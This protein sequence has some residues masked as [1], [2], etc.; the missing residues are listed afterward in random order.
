VLRNRPDLV[1]QWSDEQVA[2]RWWDLFPARKDRNGKPAEPEAHEL[3]MLLP[4]MATIRGRL[5]SMS[6]FMRCLAEP[7]AR[8]SNREDGCSGR[9]WEGRYRCQRLLDEAAVLACSV[10]VDLNPIRA[11]IAQTPETSEYTSAYERIHA[12][13]PES[14][15]NAAAPGYNRAL[16]RPKSPSQRNGPGARRLPRDGWLSPIDLDSQN[17]AGGRDEPLACHRRSSD[18]GFLSMSREQ[19]L[20]ILDW[21]GRQVRT[22]KRGSIPGH[23]VPIFE[24]LGL[25][26]EEWVETV[27]QF[28]RRFHRAAGRPA[29]LAREA[30]RHGR[31]WFHGLRTARTAFS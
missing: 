29:G 28:G 14:A 5:S 12:H 31:R 30:A 26:T 8:R 23:L 3:R 2:R 6:W 16:P 10:Y 15:G 24:R 4:A 20:E 22:D 1:A 19:Y 18:K 21:T 9:F 11:G 25:A 7:I 17:A 27:R 13:E